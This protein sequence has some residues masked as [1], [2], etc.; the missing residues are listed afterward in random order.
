MAGKEASVFIID[1][2]PSMGQIITGDESGLDLSKRAMR[3]LLQQKLLF[4]K[5]DE[6]SII[7]VG[8]DE[9][10]N[11]L[12]RQAGE[13]E[14]ENISVL[15][16][17]MRA[18]L[19]HLTIIDTIDTSNSSGDVINALL[20]AMQM[21]H[22][23]VK[24]YKFTKRIW[25][26]T[27]AAGEIL[28]DPAG[29][30]QICEGFKSK[31]Y[32]IN[33]IGVNFD[34]QENENENDGET[35]ENEEETK[36]S[37]M[38]DGDDENTGNAVN[39]SK[40]RVRP[41]RSA[42]QIKNQKLLR[43]LCD[44]V[45]GS[46]MDSKNAI[47]ILSNIRRSVNQ[48]T[49]YRGP[50]TIGDVKIE[51]FTYG[52]TS[53]Q[54]LPS[55]KKEIKRSQE[56]ISNENKNENPGDDEN[57]SME[58]SKTISQQRT[59]YDNK[60]ESGRTE[61][62][63][64]MR[65][66]GFHYGHELI[67]FTDEQILELK[68]QNEKC[69]TVL[70]FLE[71]SKLNRCQFMGVVDCVISAPGDTESG[72]ALSAFIHGLIELDK[73]AL[74]RYVKR[75]NDRPLLGVLIPHIGSIECLW[76]NQLPFA[77]DVRDFNFASIESNPAFMPNE[78]QMAATNSLIQAMDLMTAATDADGD[79]MEA[80]Q[81]SFTFNPVLQRF[82]DNVQRRAMDPSAEIAELD[83]TIAKY[84]TPD[85]AMLEKA[86]GAFVNFQRVFPLQVIDKNE[87]KRKRQWNFYETNSSNQPPIDADIEAIKKSSNSNNDENKSNNEGE[88]LTLEDAFK[89][90]ISLIGSV[91]PVKDF[92]S[93]LDRRDD[94][95]IIDS[96]FT[97]MKLIITDL[98]KTSYGDALFD[99]AVECIESLR[100][101]CIKFNEAEI[102]NLF[103]MNQ[104]KNH[105]KKLKPGIWKKLEEK[106]IYP[107]SSE[108]VED[109]EINQQDSEKFY[110]ENSIILSNVESLPES[111]NDEEDLFADME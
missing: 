48:V 14:Y 8:S 73:V 15:K 82:Y 23:R 34:E 88:N 37:M 52:K 18:E 29:F 98:I 71:T 94:P 102:F 65:V 55:L 33:I 59:Y 68:P 67:A 83:P 31:D 35:K 30:D 77:E 38:D 39:R 24:H 50:L 43:E 3:L 9:T 70:A 100:F 85:P 44:R 7:T 89:K 54:N 40:S 56:N 105:L 93:M 6:F 51:V 79:T 10:D 61:V 2:N 1:V 81:P 47:N 36:S 17:L 22:D 66:K 11:E 25:L 49:K 16:T 19:D 32:K 84:C 64:D 97:Q 109:S 5:S 46:M 87:K 110:Q 92:E 78:E 101:Q 74:C 60:A 13:G 57:S 75:S 41:P 42:T 106:K 45:G 62:A 53:L 95:K 63:D 80:F 91:T 86:H 108:E 69:L 72:A 76:F 103:L 12:N 4:P 90:Q 107:I 58:E 26:F 96:A 27:D 20:V 28:D 21:L 111:N 104:I 99:K